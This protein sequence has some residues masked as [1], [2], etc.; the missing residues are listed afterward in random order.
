MID[1]TK[2]IEW[3]WDWDC[4]NDYYNGEECVP[5]LYAD[6][7]RFQEYS[8]Y[9]AEQMEL[10]VT[11]LNHPAKRIAELEAERDLLIYKYMVYR[12]LADEEYGV[13]NDFFDW[14]EGYL[15]ADSDYKE[16]YAQLLITESTVP[17]PLIE[18]GDCAG[19]GWTHEKTNFGTWKVICPNCEH[20]KIQP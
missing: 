10:L 14:N 8:D 5:I 7:T 19:V 11:E 15:A 12:R 16:R 3:S 1:I 6:G 18:C 4:T 17:L 9:D 2:V 13:C 20:G